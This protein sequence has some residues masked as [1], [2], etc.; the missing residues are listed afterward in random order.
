MIHYKFISSLKL[1]F[2]SHRSS[3][4][5][6]RGTFR[7]A[8]DCFMERYLHG[9]CIIL[10]GCAASHWGRTLSTAVKHCWWKEMQTHDLV[11]V[12][13]CIFSPSYYRIL[14]LA[15]VLSLN[16]VEAVEQNLVF[17]SLTQ[18]SS[19]PF[20]NVVI[21]LKYI[22]CQDVAQNRTVV[23]CF[24]GGEWT[25]KLLE[26]LFCQLQALVTSGISFYLRSV[27]Q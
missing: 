26:V 9:I 3:E 2:L 7:S 25:V 18:M 12:P 8:L 24:C 11:S 5:R 19:S 10:T 23:L 20:S 6:L 16:F 15:Q 27:H 21:F 14:A 13:I 17:S 1:W 4:Q 22:R